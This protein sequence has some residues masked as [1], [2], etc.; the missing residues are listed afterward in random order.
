[1]EGKGCGDTYYIGKEIF[2]VGTVRPVKETFKI[3][4]L[5]TCDYFM[6]FTI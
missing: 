3:D 1:M 4:V 2:F 6:G 5:S